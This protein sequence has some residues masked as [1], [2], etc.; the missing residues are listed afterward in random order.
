MIR[1]KN[2]WNDGSEVDHDSEGIGRSIWLV[3]VRNCNDSE[4]VRTWWGDGGYI[5]DGV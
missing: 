3:V 1:E 4:A 5:C 2:N